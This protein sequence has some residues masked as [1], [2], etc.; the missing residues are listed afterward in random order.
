M[1]CVSLARAKELIYAT[2]GLGSLEAEDV[3]L[4]HF[5]RHAY[6]PEK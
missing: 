3:F 1:T 6:D 2:I 5:K 4:F